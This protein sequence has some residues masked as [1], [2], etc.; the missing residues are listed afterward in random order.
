[1]DDR[2]FDEFG[3]R[4]ADRYSRR[5]VLGLVAAA[6]AA[7]RPDR[8]ATA[9]GDG[10]LSRCHTPGQ[11]C[12]SER[13]AIP[14]CFGG[15]ADGVCCPEGQFAGDRCCHEYQVPC[16]GICCPPETIACGAPTVLP[17]GTVLPGTC[18]CP[19]GHPYCGNACC[20][21]HTPQICLNGLCRSLCDSDVGCA[22]KAGDIAI[23]VDGLCCREWEICGDTCCLE[24][25]C[26]G[27][28][29]QI[30]R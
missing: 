29:C 30:A 7:F 27:G 13:G 21:I 16:Y 17:D 23:C 28:E 26:I 22:S 6:V 4:L 9:Q 11:S 3:R 8:H 5:G 24:G 25:E 2:H 20:G 14:C 1:M 15:C 10:R 12:S 19:E 18:I